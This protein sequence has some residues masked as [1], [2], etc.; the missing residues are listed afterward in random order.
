MYST[1]DLQKAIMDI[2][3]SNVSTKFLF[4]KFLKSTVLL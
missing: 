1:V 2:M 4:V 3:D